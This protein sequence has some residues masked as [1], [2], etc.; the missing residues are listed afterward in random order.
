LGLGTALS[1][2]RVIDNSMKDIEITPL[3]KRK[4]EKRRIPEACDGVT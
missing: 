4:M 3:A 1:G 2:A